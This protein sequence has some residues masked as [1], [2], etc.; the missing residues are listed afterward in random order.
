MEEQEQR[1][2]F[3]SKY[4]TG[5]TVD[6]PYMD[7]K[8]T[9]AAF[10]NKAA[11]QVFNSIF[12]YTYNEPRWITK[13]LSVS[14]YGF[15]LD[16]SGWMLIR[17][18]SKRN[19]KALTTIEYN[20]LVDS[21]KKTMS[22][23]YGDY[24]YV[25]TDAT[26]D[27]ENM[28]PNGK[29]KCLLNALELKGAENFE[30]HGNWFL[31][32]Y[33][34]KRYELV[35][36]G[37]E[38]K[39]DDLTTP[40]YLGT[41]YFTRFMQEIIADIYESLD[42]NSNAGYANSG[43]AAT[44]VADEPLTIENG[45]TLDRKYY[46]ASESCA[47][48][49]TVVPL[50]MRYEMLKS[51]ETVDRRVN[52]VDYYVAIK[53]GYMVENDTLENQKEALQKLC[54]NFKAEQVDAI[55]LAIYNFEQRGDALIVADATGVG[56]GRIVAGLM[57]Y[58]RH[59]GKMPVF[60]TEK[61][62]LFSDIYRDLIDI[63]AD[64]NIP[65][66]YFDGY[67]E[68]ETLVEKVTDSGDG[69]DVEEEDDD[70]NDMSM[71]IQDIQLVAR[72]KRNKNYSTDVQGK[73]LFKPFIIN[74]RS[75]KT[76]VKNKNG[77]VLY[78]APSPAQQKSIFSSGEVPADCACVITT[79]SQVA[80]K[81]AVAKREFLRNIVGGNAVL[82]MDEAHNASGTSQTGEF[83]TDIVLTSYATGFFSATFAKRPDN[84]P[85]YAIKTSMRDANLTTQQLIAAI[86]YG[87]VALQEIIAAQLVAEGQ[88][89]RREKSF[90]GVEVNYIY[91]DERQEQGE[92]PKPYLNLK[93][94]HIAVFDKS[95]EIIREIIEFQ[96]EF[97][98]PEI[99]AMDDAVK[100]EQ[101][102]VDKKKGTQDLGIS[103]APPFSGIF[104]IIN[105]LLFA[106]KAEAV[107]LHAIERMKQGKKALIAFANTM[108]SFL[109]TLT[110]D[111]GK[112]VSE[113]TKI[114]DDF[115][116][117][118]FKRFESIFKYTVQ[119]MVYDDASGEFETIKEHKKL[120]INLFSEPAQKEYI[121][122]RRKI[123][124]TTIGI[125]ASPLDLIQK[126]INDAGFSTIEVTGRETRIKIENDG[127]ATIVPRV[128]TPS[129][130]A[131]RMFN[132]NDVDCLLLNQSGATGASAH[133][134]RSGQAQKVNYDKNNNPIIPSSLLPKDEIKQRCMII[135]QPELDINKEVQK[136]GR[137]HRT[138]QVFLPIYDY[139]ISAIP[140]EERLMMMLQR[141][142]KSLDANTSSNQ[143][144]S[145]NVIDVNDFLNK[146]GDDICVDYLIENKEVNLMM[147]DPLKIFETDSSS[148]GVAKGSNDETPEQIK[149]RINTQ[150]AAYRVAGRV[151]ILP[152]KMQQHFYSELT[153][154]YASQVQYL[155]ETGQ[156]DLEV[157]ALNLQA[158]S[159]QRSIIVVGKETGSVF[160]RHTILEKCTVNNLSKPYKKSD[161]VSMIEFA[162]KDD[163]GV[164]QTPQSI[165][166]QIL[167]QFNSFMSNKLEK[168]IEEDKQ[169]YESLKEKITSETKY[170]KIPDESRVEKDMYIETRSAEI[171]AA[172]TAQISLL[173]KRNENLVRTL[174][175][176]FKSFQIGKVI[177]YREPGGDTIYKGICLG[178]KI[179]SKIKNPYSPSSI[180]LKVAIASSTRMLNI[181]LSQNHVIQEIITNTQAHI[182]YS[183]NLNTLNDWDEICRESSASRITRYIATGNILQAMAKEE[184]KG[185]KLITYTTITGGKKQGL[186]MYYG[187][188]PQMANERSNNRR[189][190]I[191]VT[192]PI[193]QAAK[194][195]KGLVPGNNISIGNDI[196]LG[197]NYNYNFVLTVPAAKNR[198]GKFYLN[199]E[200]NA[201]SI[202]GKFEKQSSSFVAQFEQ[203]NFTKL[204]EILGKIGLNLQL[205]TSQFDALGIEVPEYDDE[206]TYERATEILDELV[207][208][209]K[210]AQ[211]ELTQEELERI[212]AEVAQHNLLEEQQ[213][214]ELN[215]QEQNKLRAQKEKDL[216][217]K[218]FKATSL[219]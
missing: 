114:K 140:A 125:T 4:Y 156:Y 80:S 32:D 131:F 187:W 67:E 90:E 174:S 219:L 185:G 197:K 166:E 184:L 160:S 13:D 18:D 31:F 52:G 7:E 29:E 132:S 134:I 59:N 144:Q 188:S 40:K 206:V 152:I 87:G 102:E 77:D 205:T 3:D 133:S 2:G 100:A 65:Q 157:T 190:S 72:Y 154:R 84:M 54:N 61:P 119:K 26:F 99:K 202:K 116:L 56:K 41:I 22:E 76:N 165:T 213:R 115:S 168:Q 172:L 204:V 122:L 51:I 45:E 46:P 127:T 49:D 200:L 124:E 98:D 95:T 60:F 178:F 112:Y 136:R 62:S 175:Y 167:N 30:L 82:L 201:L 139:I 27:F 38:F 135:L 126:L 17:G 159:I 198:G 120:N 21:Y 43:E 211:E 15:E 1:V 186:L 217:L 57:V 117:I 183:D 209:D 181:P 177:A 149:A 128:P 36:N 196:S 130:D 216:T 96:R 108:E 173:T 138:G 137:A 12:Y 110:D 163:Q 171:D 199:D 207:K 10:S 151:A 169:W 191:K 194:I 146:Y 85:I 71:G 83:L 162:C 78:K 123:Q 35:D 92:Y 23:G 63:G 106:T 91:C 70:E 48:N 150:D 88:M 75:D 203:H 24:S 101:G 193:S 161:I 50:S 113:G 42:E 215:E 218:L 129:N 105:Q 142:L 107:A 147:G 53:L 195:L 5:G 118:F 155:R 44:V 58:A 55:A 39:L 212:D 20:K 182:T 214:A 141:K 47:S 170:K 66:E 97:I 34:G 148:D 8:E 143:K 103:N 68:V 81:R 16:R 37:T 93:D 189:E 11:A 9:Y 210:L 94:K 86:L 74:S 73:K 33:K 208:P 192:V 19:Y 145:T 111:E 25:T 64:P 121:R 109:S 69:A 104:Q 6:F 164:V 28:Q 158:E 89:I 79:Y 153:E 180:K 176:I 179:D 14:V